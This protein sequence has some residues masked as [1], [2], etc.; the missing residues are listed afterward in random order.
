MRTAALKLRQAL[1]ELFAVFDLACAIR[2]NV[3]GGR[4][5]ARHAF[6]D[7]ASARWM[8]LSGVRPGGLRVPVRVLGAAS[9]E[10]ITTDEAG[11]EGAGMSTDAGLLARCD[12]DSGESKAVKRGR[13]S[14]GSIT[15]DDCGPPVRPTSLEEANGTRST[16]L[17]DPPAPIVLFLAPRAERLVE[18]REGHQHRVEEQRHQADL[19]LEQ[20]VD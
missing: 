17:D 8:P 11:G 4:D 5:A 12:S 6:G 18:D 9:G 16:S 1:L 3:A 2:I 15:S 19:A 10:T 20:E 7:S 14:T 13:P